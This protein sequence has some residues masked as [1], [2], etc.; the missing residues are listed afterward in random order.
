MRS[1]FQA[2]VIALSFS[3]AAFAQDEHPSAP[4]GTA[5]PYAADSGWL[6]NLGP[7]ESTVYIREVTIPNSSWLRLH[8]G[9]ETTLAPG[10]YL[11][12]TS[13]LDGEQQRLDFATLAMWDNST[14]Y[15]NGQTVILELRAAPNSVGNRVTLEQLEQE[16]FVPRGDGNQCGICGTDDRQ[17]SAEDWVARLMP[18]GCTASIICP[19]GTMISAGHCSGTGQIVQFRVPPSQA[20]CNYVNP[21]V[22]DQ[23]PVLTPSAQNGGVG[24]DW[25]V[26]RAGTNGAGQNPYDRYGAFR[27]LAATPVSFNT[28]ASL[29]GHGVDLTCVRSG[30]QQTANGLIT[31]TAATYYQYNIDLRGGNSG[32]SLVANNRIIGVVT[33]CSQGCPNYATRIDLPAFANAINAL[34]SCNDMELSVQT[35]GASNVTITLTPEDYYG[36]TGGV[37]PFTRGYALGTVVTLSAPPGG[38]S[39]T[40]FQRWVVGGVPQGP[41]TSVQITLNSAVTAVAEYAA[42]SLPVISQ[43]PQPQTTCEGGDATFGVTASPATAF[44][45]QRLAGAWQSLAD[46]VAPSGMVIVGSATPLLSLTNVG[47]ADAGSYRCLVNNQC[48][49]TGSLVGTLTVQGPCG[50]DPDVN[51]DGAVNGF[52]IQATEEAVNGDFSNFCQS[53][54]D[55]NGDGSENGFDIETEEQRVNGAPC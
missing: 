18:V 11:L 13:T 1:V 32:S 49:G 50:C 20:N 15:F 53:T 9:P 43:Q 7:A 21:P 5:V 16:V 28:P 45:W 25:M 54:A 55:L 44:Q 33:H 3:L 48:R 38:P 6:D 35:T 2:G 31:G 8:F 27:A 14:A 30:T 51:C 26:F 23:F 41:A 22:A 37:A 52:D 46:G 4:V 47:A 29:T 42:A 39:S 24:A 36:R 40:C 34:M 19:D 10:S 17:P 12:A